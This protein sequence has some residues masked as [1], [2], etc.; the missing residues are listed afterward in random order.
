MAA[1]Y[2][3]DFKSTW[4]TQIFLAVCSSYRQY[5]IRQSGSKHNIKYRVGPIFSVSVESACSYF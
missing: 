3:E 1:S 4:L 5:F 2:K